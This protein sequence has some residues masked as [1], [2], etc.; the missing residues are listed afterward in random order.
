MH[1]LKVLFS[2]AFFGLNFSCLDIFLF[3]KKFL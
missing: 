1:M 2:I 3:L